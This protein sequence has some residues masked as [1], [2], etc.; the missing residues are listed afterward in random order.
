M[1]IKKEDCWNIL[2]GKCTLPEVMRIF[3]RTQTEIDKT[4]EEIKHADRH[5]SSNYFALAT[6]FTIEAYLHLVELKEIDDTKIFN[7]ASK[8]YDDGN[9]ILGDIGV[10]GKKIYY[11]NRTWVQFIK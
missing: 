2:N 5:D 1:K 10:M 9:A 7:L 4:I 6:M 3:G 11:K 8:K